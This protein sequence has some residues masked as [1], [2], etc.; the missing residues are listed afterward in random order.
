MEEKQ[1][2]LADAL[3]ESERERSIARSRSQLQPQTSDN[4]DG[5]NCIDCP[6][7]IPQARIQMGRIRCVECQTMI[8]R[9]SK[10]FA[11]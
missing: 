10:L 8:E 4:F 3:V 6:S 1:L 9:R 11:R 7:E 5:K 2:E